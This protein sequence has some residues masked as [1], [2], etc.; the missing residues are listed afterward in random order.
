MTKEE[1]L[2]ALRRMAPE[3]GSLNCLGCGDERSCST[4][5][6]AICREAIE[7]I[8]QLSAEIDMLREKFTPLTVEELREMDGK[9]IY[10][11]AFGIMQTLPKFDSGFVMCLADWTNLDGYG[12]TW[13]AFRRKREGGDAA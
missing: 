11:A 10:V 4:H 6:C 2:E 13:L 7:L 9:P 12:K 8:E 3:T 5:G 1:L